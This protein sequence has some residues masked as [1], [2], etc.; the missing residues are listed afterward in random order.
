M[1]MPDCKEVYV[2]YFTPRSDEIKESKT[3]Y[4][5]VKTSGDMIPEGSSVKNTPES[6]PWTVGSEAVTD[7]A[8]PIRK[9]YPSRTFLEDS[10]AMSS[11]YT[12]TPDKDN[13]FFSP[14]RNSRNQ[15]WSRM[16]DSGKRGRPRADVINSLIMEGSQSGSNI[17]CKICSR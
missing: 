2:E 1:S 11:S 13:D 14:E 8:T 15:D 3:Y 9:I 17:K 12:L 16:Q 10:L 4:I 5:T 6:D 7:P